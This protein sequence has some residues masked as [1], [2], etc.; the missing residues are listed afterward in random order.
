MIRHVQSKDRCRGRQVLG[1]ALCAWVALVVP[2]FAADDA[3]QVSQ[4]L[5]D[6]GIRFDEDAARQASVQALLKAVDPRAR[7]VG[8]E[9]ARQIE[10]TLH[11][12][13]CTGRVANAASA[14]N[15]SS[16]VSTSGVVAAEAWPQG[17]G[18]LKVS[19]LYAGTGTEL[20]N[21][22]FRLA[23]RAD[24]TGV[25]LDIRGANGDDMDSADTAAGVFDGRQG[26]LYKIMD[27]QGNVVAT[28]VRPGSPPVRPPVMLLT[29]GRTSCAAELLAAVLSGRN[30]VMLI[31]SP[32][33][34]DAS[35][36][37]VIPLPDGSNYLYV[38][39]R[40][41]VLPDGSTYQGT[42]VKPDVLVTSPTGTPAVAMSGSA[43]NPP[44]PSASATND[45][46]RLL[47]RIGGD[48]A[49]GRAADILLGLKALGIH[50]A[51]QSAPPSR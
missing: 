44:P 32:T 16:L 18:Y 47:Q 41:I 48:V 28:H 38:A 30:G 3:A 45:L 26:D 46:S 17:V 23:D 50:A 49:L 19:G 24:P 6:H 12:F 9:E 35:L 29:D 14:T 1:I 10:L 7:I 22:L 43:T 51:K 21:Q 42:G 39:S 34:G 13:L 2:A 15:A 4:V 20:T 33:A 31:G 5:R 37:D 11:G 36:R 8:R 25:I 27:S 40:R